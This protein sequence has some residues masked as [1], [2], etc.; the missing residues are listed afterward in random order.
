MIDGTIATVDTVG[1]TDQVS[2]M[3]IVTGTTITTETS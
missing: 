2:A 3:G 1:G